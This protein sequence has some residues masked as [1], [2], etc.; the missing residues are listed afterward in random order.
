LEEQNADPFK[1]AAY[2]KSIEKYVATH[3]KILHKCDPISL[4]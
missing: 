1:K 3:K 2:M 4:L